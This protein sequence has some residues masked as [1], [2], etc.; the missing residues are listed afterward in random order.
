VNVAV[1]RDGCQEL[2]GTAL[3]PVLITSLV[4]TAP[5]TASATM[6]TPVARWMGNANALLVGRGIDATPVGNLDTDF[7]FNKLQLVIGNFFFL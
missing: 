6:E 1:F 3:E 5:K 7:F 4:L 2:E